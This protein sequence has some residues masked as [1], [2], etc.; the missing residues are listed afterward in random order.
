MR[1]RVNACARI[2]RARARARAGARG[3]TLLEL[4]GDPRRADQRCWDLVLG[5]AGLPLQHLVR[6][7]CAEWSCAQWWCTRCCSAVQC[8]VQCCVQ[9]LYT[10][11]YTAVGQWY[12]AL[13]STRC[14]TTVYTPVYSYV[15]CI[16]WYSA[17]YTALTACC[18]STVPLYIPLYTAVCTTVHH[19]CTG[20][21]TVWSSIDQLSNWVCV[22]Y[23]TRHCTQSAVP[24]LTL[25]ALTHQA[26]PISQ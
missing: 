3:D 22:T 14:C 12:R 23:L 24:Q 21:C 16:Q 26:I 13:Y 20:P 9:C 1:A 19:R 4:Y 6:R 2:M 15:Q 11:V 18:Q 25:T 10:G 5:P 17:V 8:S 7:C